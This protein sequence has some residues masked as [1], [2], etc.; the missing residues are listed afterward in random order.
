MSE[1]KP[2]I[3]LA[4]GRPRDPS[5]M[6]RSLSRALQECGKQKPKVAYVGVANKDSVAFFTAIKALL[7]EAGAGQVTLVRL[8]KTGAD[9]NAAKKVLESSDVIFLSGGEVEDGMRWLLEHELIDFLKALYNNGTL[10]VG[11][12]AGSI[13][14]GTHW[15]RW[16][17]PADDATAELFDCLGLIPTVFDTHA[18]DEDWKEL[19]MVLHL[20]GPGTHGYGIPR[21]GMIRADNQGHLENLEKE[22]LSF[23]NSDG[24]LQRI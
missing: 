5:G 14:M 21:D 17:N 9:K 3:L 19:K 23:I 20:M 4:G 11:M 7:K 8:A 10:F 2:M 15:V 16:G 6:V 18:E 24:R 1:P 13:M 22:L 12:S